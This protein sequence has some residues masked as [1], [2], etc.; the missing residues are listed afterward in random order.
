MT[1]LRRALKASL[2]VEKP[3]SHRGRGGS[4]GDLAPCHQRF[5]DDTGGDHDRSR[6]RSGSSSRGQA[7]RRGRSSGDGG[8]D[9]S[10]DADSD[11]SDG[12][13]SD[14]AV[15]MTSSRGRATVPDR[16]N[17]SGGGTKPKQGEAEPV[18]PPR[19]SVIAA[20][21]QPE[22]GSQI[23]VKFD[24]GHWYSGIILKVDRQRGMIRIDYDD[25]TQ[26]VSDIPDSDIVIYPWRPAEQRVRPRSLSQMRAEE[27][28]SKK[29]AVKTESRLA[30]APP[31]GKSAQSRQRQSTGGKR[32]QARAPTSLEGR[33]KGT[34]ETKARRKSRLQQRNGKPLPSAKG[35]PSSQR[36][37]SHKR[38]GGR[39]GRIGSAPKRRRGPRE[40]TTTTGGHSSES[41]SAASSSSEEEELDDMSL[42]IKAKSRSPRASP[43]RK[44]APMTPSPKS[45]GSRPGG[46]DV[47]SK[48]AMAS[49]APSSSSSG[50][51]DSDC[52]RSSSSSS[53]NSG[54]DDAGRGAAGRGGRSK[55]G[56]SPGS[57]PAAG[58]T[59]GHS[60][61]QGDEGRR[62]QKAQEVRGAV[63][64]TVI[65]PAV[66]R[67]VRTRLFRP[68]LT[69][70][71]LVPDL[72][73]AYASCPFANGN[74]NQ[75]HQQQSPKKN[76][77]VPKPPA[78]VVKGARANTAVKAETQEAENS[79][80]SAAKAQ[81]RRD[82]PLVEVDA[83]L[84][85]A[86]NGVIGSGP[87]ARGRG[88]RGHPRGGRAKQA[89]SGRA[90]PAPAVVRSPEVER[91][92]EDVPAKADTPAPQESAERK[93]EQ[94]S[95]LPSSMR[96]SPRSKETPSSPRLGAEMTESPSTGAP[97][98]AE[99][100][101]AP[102]GSGPA[103]PDVSSPGSSI[104]GEGVGDR[105]K[106]DVGANGTDGGKPAAAVVGRDT[107]PAAEAEGSSPE[108][109]PQPP[110]QPHAAVSRETGQELEKAED[111]T[112]EKQESDVPPDG[113]TRVEE[114]SEKP[115]PPRA[116][117]AAVA[118]VAKPEGGAS[119][120][121]SPARPTK[122]ETEA[123]KLRAPPPKSSAVAPIDAASLSAEEATSS[124]EG[125]EGLRAN[126]IR[127][128]A[129]GAIP[130]DSFD[131]VAS[132]PEGESCASEK[133]RQTPSASPAVASP[134]RSAAV[135]A[136]E[137]EDS[138]PEEDGGGADAE[139]IPEESATKR[140]FPAKGGGRKAAKSKSADEAAPSG[141][142]PD[143]NGRV[144]G[145][146]VRKRPRSEEK[147]GPGARCWPPPVPSRSARPAPESMDVD[148]D[149]SGTACPTNSASSL[150]PAVSPAKNFADSG[151]LG[152]APSR[153]LPAAAKEGRAD[154]TRRADERPSS[155][156]EEPQ[157]TDE[158]IDSPEPAIE[159]PSAL[160][161]GKK[162]EADGGHQGQD[163]GSGEGGAGGGVQKERGGGSRNSS[164]AEGRP[165]PGVG[166]EEAKLGAVERFA[167][168]SSRKS[169][170]ALGTGATVPAD[171]G[172][173]AAS[174][175]L[176]PA[177]LPVVPAAPAAG[178][179][180]SALPSAMEE[181]ES[182]PPARETPASMDV[183]D[184]EK[185]DSRVQ[186][187]EDEV[188]GGSVGRS[189]ESKVLSG[190]AGVESG[191]AGPGDREKE[192]RRASA[193]SKHGRSGSTDG[194]DG[195]GEE[196]RPG[197]RKRSG[198]TRFEPSMDPDRNRVGQ[199]AERS[200]R[201]AAVLASKRL[202]ASAPI[203]RANRGRVRQLRAVVDFAEYAQRQRAPRRMALPHAELGKAHR[204]LLPPEG[205]ASSPREGGHGWDAAGRGF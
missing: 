44:T 175:S 161:N 192:D 42:G 105:V 119:S 136:M 36:P 71:N 33:M 11:E 148:D 202:A 138:G 26:E 81:D 171:D 45:K 96:K 198:V 80:A 144:G 195:A 30:W 83:S 189:G 109:D 117:A 27:K 121:D 173:A 39:N 59:G 153:T 23:K 158:G 160:G 79:S 181:Q 1:S 87:K 86:S 152:R 22:V 122:A 99:A 51:S 74:I 97:D 57:E 62:S 201:Q 101:G 188:E 63:P 151:D 31:R 159:L 178:D 176:P 76:K 16:R 132:G 146:P 5:G 92:A 200:E 113:G 134:P 25:G 104:Y 98:V 43:R 205:P 15:P 85:R 47:T 102:V 72:V 40:G 24:T 140:R 203:R 193:T 18:S 196:P 28:A 34:P 65:S 126:G 37:A 147:Q 180:S 64:R 135:D 183:R 58:S 204:G 149:E 2:T 41:S 49:S 174:S 169:G 157:T 141:N 142:D 100:K 75:S 55:T 14:D 194:S 90:K 110:P 162:A 60:S 88:G 130:V 185:G 82:S 61:S 166:D 54:S 68:C 116:K 128:A 91:R 56:G 179:A 7:G 106:S 21:H 107:A 172:A 186:M 6:A 46:N 93:D 52:S 163:P 8:D 9:S 32:E 156:S 118:S 143:R 190:E 77:P 129:S 177:S 125:E 115:S 145:S 50:S 184:S 35:R 70:S 73:A 29:V 191:D 182:E 120:D 187:R 199:R 114:A 3:P 89:K 95:D 103:P 133:G 4:A 10:E 112:K 167:S 139:S 38:P 170:A 20:A 13:G 53:A 197:G 78:A 66:D 168:S 69:L 154:P 127:E 123:A 124:G 19:Q 111:A 94:P 67:V 17:G 137:V 12:S 150:D 155:P 164:I 84:T 165:A 48:G 131:G 108:K